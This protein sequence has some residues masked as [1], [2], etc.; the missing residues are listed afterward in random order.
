MPDVMPL[1]HL[2]TGTGNE[3]KTALQRSRAEGLE[4]VRASM[5]ECT[6]LD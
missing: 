6:L 1:L 2:P 4:L 5:L 3:G